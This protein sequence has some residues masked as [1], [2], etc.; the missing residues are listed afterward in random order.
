MTSPLMMEGVVAVVH[1]VVPA[2]IKEVG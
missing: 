1:Q 2:T